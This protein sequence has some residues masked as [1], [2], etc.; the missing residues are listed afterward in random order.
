[1]SGRAATLQRCP[2]HFSFERAQTP[3]YLSHDGLAPLLV[4]FF[5]PHGLAP[6]VADSGAPNRQRRS[7]EREERTDD[8]AE[9]SA[10]EV[11][12]RH[13]L[14]IVIDCVSRM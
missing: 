5:K 9:E 10:G 14:M 12:D 8:A 11:G 2:P 7:K 13:E 1:M 3:D 4:S 6:T